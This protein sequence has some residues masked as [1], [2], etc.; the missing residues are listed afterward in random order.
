MI[1]CE[2]GILWW[3]SGVVC[4][5]RVWSPLITFLLHCEVSGELHSYILTL[6][7]VEWVM[8]RRGGSIRC[9]LV[10]EIWRLVPLCVTWCIWHERNSWFFE[11]VEILVV[12]LQKSMHNMLHMW[13]TAHC[14]L[15][16]PTLVDFVNLFSSSFY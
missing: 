1:I 7:G 15:D 11:D 6:F 3:L 4:A 14:S 9:S 5:R 12:E 2:R 13:I 10:K 16:V 8:L